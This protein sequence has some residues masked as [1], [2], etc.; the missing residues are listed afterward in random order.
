MLLWDQSDKLK[1]ACRDTVSV[2]GGQDIVD[3][4][5]Y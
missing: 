3:V 5:S 1:E 4:Y 2:S